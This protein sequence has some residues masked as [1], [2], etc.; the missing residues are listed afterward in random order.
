MINNK[1]DKGNVLDFLERAGELRKKKQ[2]SNPYSSEYYSPEEDIGYMQDIGGISKMMQ[3]L[4]DSIGEIRMEEFPFLGRLKK[5]YDIIF[6][7][8]VGQELNFEE[9]ELMAGA[10]DIEL[11]MARDVALSRKLM[12]QGN[13]SYQNY[14]SNWKLIMVIKLLGRDAAKKV[15]DEMKNGKDK[16]R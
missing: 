15:F 8:E 16:G 7:L 4:E 10:T 9:I 13:D 12:K 6:K 5:F 11:K 14:C 3:T 2:G 1:D